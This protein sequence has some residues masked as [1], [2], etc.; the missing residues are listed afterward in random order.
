MITRRNPKATRELLL[1]AAF[2]EIFKSGFQAASLDAILKETGVT[3]GALY[4]HFP[5]K[6]ALGHAVIDEVIGHY[7]HEL[8]VKSLEGTTDP[9]TAMQTLF[10]EKSQAC[11][12]E[13]IMLGC[14]LNNLA[15]EMSPVDEEFR[16]H[17][18]RLF[19][20]WKDGM[21]DA[22]QRGQSAGTVRQDIDADRVATFI[23]ATLEGSLGM[24]KAAQSVDLLQQNMDMMIHYL[25][26]LRPTEGAAPTQAA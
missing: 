10:R 14:P 19:G 20:L 23:L 21:A 26:G 11:T 6:A 18:H 12:E 2:W 8:W 7:L 9:V 1:E 4:H 15:M 5:S 25:E 3:K 22:L 13:E 17:I 24:A 16:Q